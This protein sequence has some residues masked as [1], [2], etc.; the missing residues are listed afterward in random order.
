MATPFDPVPPDRSSEETQNLA[1]QQDIGEPDGVDLLHLVGTI[2]NICK[3]YQVQVLNAQLQRSYRAYRNEHATASKY[4]GVDFRGRSRL[5]V[6]KTRSAVRKNM[7]SA[8]A[9]LFASQ[10]AIKVT[11]EYED[12]PRQ[13]ASAAVLGEDLNYR[14]SRTSRRSGL[15][16][17][18][19]AMGGLLDSQRTNI[20]VSKQYWEYEEIETGEMEDV[21]HLEVD[22]D[23]NPA[24]QRDENGN[25]LI[26]A[27]GNPVLNLVEGQEPVT[28][29]VADRPMIQILPIENI[30]VDPAA[31]WYEP[32][33]L[34]AF[35]KARYPMRL[36]EVRTMMEQES[37]DGSGATW[38]QDVPD[39]VLLKGRIED[40]RD[41][42]RR[43]REGGTDRYEENL[44]SNS[45]FDVVWVQ[46]NFIRIGGRDLNFW[47][48]GR[49]GFI[50]TV[51][52]THIAYP[53]LEGERPYTM[54]F[55]QIDTHTVYSQSP[56]ETWQPLQLEINDIT[57]L[58]LDTLKRSIA[59]LV[60]VRR[61]KNVDYQQ[62]KRR[63][64]PE[65]ILSLDNLEDVEFENTPGP[66]GQSYQDS[67]I[68]SANF[69][70]LAGVFSPSTVQSNRQLNET[71]GG[72]NLLSGAGNA[73]TEF[74]LR[75]WLETWAEPALRQTLHNIRYF[76]SDE[77]VLAIAGSKAR[78]YKKFNYL[79]GLSDFENLELT[80]RVNA[81]VGA[82]DPSQKLGKLKAALEMILPMNEQMQAQGITFNF[83]EFIE[84]VMGA[85]GYKDGRRF[86][87]FGEPPEPQTPPEVAADMKKL[88]IEQE[89]VAAGERKAQLDAKT[90]VDVTELTSEREMAKAA[91]DYFASQQAREEDVRERRTD[92]IADIFLR[93]FE[94]PPQQQ[95][96]APQ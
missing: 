1:P 62:L 32:A 20:T 68:M 14:L 5:F 78:A 28:R 61:G 72:L 35:F 40:Q 37:R 36:D 51:K 57:N 90:K 25:P 3:E 30:G 95:Q 2:D 31:P 59:P 74:D 96:T 48:I 19:I 63:G 58:R 33:Q 39:S 92:R 34:G 23:G 73:V 88:E 46:E 21:Y 47:T 24:L 10:D 6:P 43:Q 18:L 55:A 86:F 69:D 56:V 84:E 65:A 49:H 87:E 15:P 85:A 66:N 29:V 82:S 79:P 67:S 11:A 76:E 42:S 52:D 71:V 77:R 93:R 12:D 9:A 16:W 64:R 50:S 38:L 89:K 81:G 4:L 44:S 26:D 53:A 80:L 22:E 60:K 41:T 27:Q 75:V 13:M 8:A 91:L 54:G 7:A 17:F 83:E 45:E 70:E 94:Q